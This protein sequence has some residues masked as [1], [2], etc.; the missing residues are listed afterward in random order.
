MNDIML[1]TTAFVQML[2]MLLRNAITLKV[3]LL[4]MLCRLRVLKLCITGYKKFVYILVG[5]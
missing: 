5:T 2:P 1:Y 4:G 3:A